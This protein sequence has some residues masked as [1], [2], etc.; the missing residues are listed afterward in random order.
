MNEFAD[1]AVY[2]IATINKAAA[3]VVTYGAIWFLQNVVNNEEALKRHPLFGSVFFRAAVALVAMGFGLDV[4]SLYIPTV[5]EVTMNIGFAALYFYM[6]RFYAETKKD[7]IT[8][9]INDE[10]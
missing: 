2:T 8:N 6:R 7:S 4:F 1:V 9:P 5:S 3:L 10:T